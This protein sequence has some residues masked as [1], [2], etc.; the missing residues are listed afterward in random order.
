MISGIFIS[1][2]T[3]DV[4]ISPE[5]AILSLWQKEKSDMFDYYFE[6]IPDENFSTVDMLVCE[7]YYMK[8]MVEAYYD[9]QIDYSTTSK[10]CIPVSEATRRK[11][12]EY[13]ENSKI[14]MLWD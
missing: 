6:F 12:I 1:R 11:I 3:M 8:R 14:K 10:Y 9:D 2:I 7:Q 4:N 13:Y 5:N